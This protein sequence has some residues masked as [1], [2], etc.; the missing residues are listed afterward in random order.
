[1]R[2]ARFTVMCWARR[3][4]RSANRRSPFETA[5]EIDPKADRP[6]PGPVDLRLLV[7][8]LLDDVVATLHKH[9]VDY[10]GPVNRTGAHGAIT[11][12]YVRD[13][14]RNLIELSRYDQE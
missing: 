8:D 7:E 6:T 9:H 14:D 1:M 11:S 5:H 4:R 13:P 2:P 3:C 10:L 12:A